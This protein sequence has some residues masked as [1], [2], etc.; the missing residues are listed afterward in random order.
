MTVG[1]AVSVGPM[2][3]LNSL[4][5]PQPTP[6]K[7]TAA[8]TRAIAATRAPVHRQSGRPADVLA[9][10]AAGPLGSCG[11]SSVNYPVLPAVLSRLWPVTAGREHGGTGR[12]GS[13]H[14][15]PA[16]IAARR[17]TIGLRQLGLVMEWAARQLTSWSSGSASW[18]WPRPEGATGAPASL[19]EPAEVAHLDLRG[20]QSPLP[21]R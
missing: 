20:A 8:A 4:E 18:P 10:A 15:E 9:L 13:G 17:S 1:G 19:Q 16:R 2:L 12:A 21:T 14:K 5:M 7:P 6:P 3:G 11:T